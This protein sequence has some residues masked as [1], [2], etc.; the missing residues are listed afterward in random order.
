MRRKL[1]LTAIALVALLI[2]TACG[3]QSSTSQ[4]STTDAGDT[5]TATAAEEAVPTEAPAEEETAPTE[6][7][8][9]EAAPTEAP[10][11]EAEPT[12]APVEEETADEESAEEEAAPAEE[13]DAEVADGVVVY[14]VDPE[15]SLIEW[16]GYR[17]AG[18]EERGTVNIADGQ[19]SVDGDQLVD[20]SF[21]IDMTSIIAHSQSGNMKDMLEGH[22]KSD[23]FFGVETYPTATFV[24]TAVE[25]TDVENEYA[26]TGDLTIKEA[27]APVE[28]TALVTEDAETLSASA[29]IIVDRSVYDVRYGSGSFFDN[30]GDDLISDDM[31][32]T[33]SL[34]ARS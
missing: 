16:Y 14:T 7:P 31:E 10:A 4:S 34:A 28:F 32:I 19:F 9:E 15:A 30:L 33:I 29:V 11:E 21:T 27:T 6:A 23:E 20:G 22:L 13:G 12:E 24:I 2:F 3:S 25:P 26:V 18:G 8:A 1:I 17:P 5:D